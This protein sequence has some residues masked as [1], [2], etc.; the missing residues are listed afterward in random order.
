MKTQKILIY[1]VIFIF[2]VVAVFAAQSLFES[3]PVPGVTSGSS[4]AI[5]NENRWSNLNASFLTSNT[6]N[7]IVA[8]GNI[9]M[10]GNVTFSKLINCDKMSTDS[11]GR[12]YCNVDNSGSATADAFNY[13]NNLTGILGPNSSIIRVGNL[14]I[15]L[16]PYQL[17]VP[18]FKNVNATDILL[19]STIIRNDN[20]RNVLSNFTDATF[21]NL[22]VY[23]NLFVIGN[24]SNVN[25]TNL[26]INGS[27]YPVID[28]TYDLGNGSLR[29]RV[30]NLSGTLETGSATIND[31]L[32]VASLNGTSLG[33]FN[34]SISLG[35]P[36]SRIPQ[37]NI[38]HRALFRRRGRFAHA[39]IPEVEPHTD[40][41]GNVALRRDDRPHRA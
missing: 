21:I 23:K 29:W 5:T 1:W 12:P 17:E 27:L 38:P 40:L 7:H 14:S 6:S 37:S 34:K 4:W 20:L 10:Q 13:A 33:L 39:R 32:K 3:S 16:S 35:I 31:D 2:L 36:I 18:A 22:V 30:L 15:I 9:T 19:N 25:I 11:N 28:S 24:I 41:V 8:L 26:N